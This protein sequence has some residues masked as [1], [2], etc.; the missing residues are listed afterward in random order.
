M[1]QPESSEPQ[2]AVELHANGQWWLLGHI[3]IFNFKL[4]DTALTVHPW[5][6][7]RTE[8]IRYDLIGLGNTEQDRS[9]RV[10]SIPQGTYVKMAIARSRVSL[11]RRYLKGG[12]R[13][14]RT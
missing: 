5:P 1:Q 11:E 9:P 12:C 4:R 2:E 6:W 3:D 14:T 13:R 8:T 7:I 10:Q